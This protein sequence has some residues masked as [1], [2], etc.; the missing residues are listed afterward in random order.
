MKKLF[1]L[2]ATCFV[3][4]VFSNCGPTKKIADT[5]PPPPPPPPSLKMTYA[6][7]LSTA[8]VNNCTPCHI[9]S[10]G[11]RKTPYD[12]FAAVKMDIDEMIRRIELNPT[13]RGFMP[14]KGTARLA[15]ST[16]AIVKQW[17]AVVLAEAQYKLR[18]LCLQ[19]CGVDQLLFPPK[20]RNDIEKRG[21]NDGSYNAE[22]YGQGNAETISSPHARNELT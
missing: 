9:P 16:I 19:R 7:N 15:D 17:K 20:L 22:T 11:G 21:K 13:D 2:T 1:A 5:P 14:F 10:K 6:A 3:L 8:I 12:N 4:F 18:Q